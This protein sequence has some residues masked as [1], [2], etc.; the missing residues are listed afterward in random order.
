MNHYGDSTIYREQKSKD[1]T[2][3]TIDYKA[4]CEIMGKHLDL[5]VE[6]NEFQVKVILKLCE[7]I[8]NLLIADTS[9]ALHIAE[10]AAAELLIDLEFTENH[11]CLNL[12]EIREKAVQKY[13]QE[14]MQIALSTK[15]MT[16]SI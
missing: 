4:T 16:T 5:F 9:D 2:T 8:D 14:Q 3:R 7:A 15:I 12:A 13:K 11:L 1:G 10:V 6:Q